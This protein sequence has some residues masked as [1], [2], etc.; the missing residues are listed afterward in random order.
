MVNNGE[1]LFRYMLA[2]LMSS[3]E[4]CLFRFLPIL[5]IGLF[6]FSFATE[7]HKFFIFFEY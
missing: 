6:F 3:L 7:L 1:H 2:I 4:K 5:L